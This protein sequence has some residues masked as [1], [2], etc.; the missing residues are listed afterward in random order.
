M[1]GVLRLGAH[2]QDEGAE[3]AAGTGAH[4]A[5]QDGGGR[6]G[7]D[8]AAAWEKSRRRTPVL[9][10]SRL[11]VAVRERATAL[12]MSAATARPARRSR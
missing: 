1:G 11:A 9:V 6:G 8:G 7:E 10:A 4:G 3:K 12:A 2:K 5:G